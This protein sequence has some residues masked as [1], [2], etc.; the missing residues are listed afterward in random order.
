M[1]GKLNACSSPKYDYLHFFIVH[2]LQRID[3]IILIKQHQQLLHTY[4]KSLCARNWFHCYESR[5]GHAWT[6]WCH[7]EKQLDNPVK[8]SGNDKAQ[9]VDG[10]CA[11]T[12]QVLRQ[13]WT[14]MHSSGRTQRLSRNE[15]ATAST[16]GGAYRS[17]AS[18]R[19]DC[20]CVRAT[21][22]KFV[23]V[24]DVADMMRY[25]V[26]QHLLLSK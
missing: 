8:F 19:Q 10:I 16:R 21:H 3:K 17:R 12:C 18:L 4:S 14:A 22:S 5:A 9:A 7:C 13:S 1:E 23:V 6:P 25:G 2:I 15:T 24:S 20:R 11:S 26:I